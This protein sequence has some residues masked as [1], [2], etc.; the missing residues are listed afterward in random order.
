[1][2]VSIAQ[3]KAEFSNLIRLLESKRE[4]SITIT[5]YGKPVAQITVPQ[6][7]PVSKRIGAASHL[8]QG[9]ISLEDFDKNNEK[10]AEMLIKG[11]L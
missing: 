11:D 3:G 5:R 7:A 1:M 9:S 8:Y 4:E 6:P 10:I 2:E